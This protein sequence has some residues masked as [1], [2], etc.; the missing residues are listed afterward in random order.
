MTLNTV[1]ETLIAAIR[2]GMPKYFYDTEK[3]KTW[4]VIVKTILSS[5][6][7]QQFCGLPKNENERDALT[8]NVFWRN[9][10]LCLRILTNFMFK[11]CNTKLVDPQK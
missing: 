8:N 6:I 9:K 10:V 5:K 7:P 3:I 11:N 4:M 2:M 1:F